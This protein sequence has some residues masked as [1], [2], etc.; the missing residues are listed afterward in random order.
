MFAPNVIFTEL[1]SSL[2]QYQTLYFHPFL[3]I[4]L[5]NHQDQLPQ[6]VNFLR[7]VFQNLLNLRFLSRT[8]HLDDV[9]CRVRRVVPYQDLQHHAQ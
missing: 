2:N 9:L 7:K 4:S 8:L 6:Q 3:Y 1:P 5:G